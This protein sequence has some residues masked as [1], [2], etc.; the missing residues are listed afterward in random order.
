LSGLRQ[1]GISVSATG[2]IPKSDLPALYSALD[3]YLLTSR[4]E[5]GPCTVFEAMAC[6]TVV[7]ATRVGAVPDL[8]VD[9]ENGYSANVDD[10]DS[11]VAAVVKVGTSPDLRGRLG[12]RARETVVRLPW[13]TVLTPLEDVYDHLVR[14]RRRAPA[15]GPH[16]MAQPNGILHTACAADALANVINRI[17]KKAV[18]PVEGLRLL[19]EMLDRKSPLDVLRGLAMLRGVTYKSRRSLSS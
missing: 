8:I 16:W 17:R 6:N 14:S 1:L 3:A 11:L 13:Q 9:G 2:Y 18:T 12:Q 19:A 5:G 15:Q 10:V 7:I 4:I